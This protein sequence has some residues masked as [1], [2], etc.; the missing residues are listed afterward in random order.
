ME[1]NQGRSSTE[2]IDL[3]A[4]FSTIATNWRTILTSIF[5]AAFLAIAYLNLTTSKYESQM[6]IA[7]TS[8]NESNKMNIPSGLA[9]LAGIG[10]G[11]DSNAGFEKFKSLLTSR[12]LAQHIADE[13]NFM[14]VVFDSQWNNKSSSWREPK[15]VTWLIKKPIKLLL[16]FPAWHEPGVEELSS[17]LSNEV[18]VKDVS[19]G[20]MIIIAF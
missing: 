18:K 17:Y 20:A 15:G 10:L 5:I 16:N 9:G 14:P 19:D 12:V 13:T 8:G 7:P 1:H 6:L 3:R 2:E 4:V 11:D